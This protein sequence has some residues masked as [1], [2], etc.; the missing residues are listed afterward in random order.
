MSGGNSQN[1]DTE[2]VSLELVHNADSVQLAAANAVQVVARMRKRGTIRGLTFASRNPSITRS[3]YQKTTLRVQS[4]GLFS[5]MPHTRTAVEKTG[6]APT[7]SFVACVGVYYVGAC[8]FSR[9]CPFFSTDHPFDVKSAEK[10]DRHQQSP[11]MDNFRSIALEPVPF[12][13]RR[14]IS[15]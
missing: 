1:R 4:A 5:L 12:S 13:A 10:W 9:L 2:C 15:V 8:P 11:S 7:F 6:L 3:G 14:F